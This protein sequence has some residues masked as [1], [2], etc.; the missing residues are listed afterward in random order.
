MAHHSSPFD[1][2]EL[3]DYFLWDDVYP[4]RADLRACALVYRS[5]VYVVQAQ[6]FEEINLGRF[7]SFH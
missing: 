6:L 2:Q 4:N 1:I 3:I 7:A 5:W